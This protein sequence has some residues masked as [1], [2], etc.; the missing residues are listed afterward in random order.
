MCESGDYEVDEATNGC[1]SLLVEVLEQED[2]AAEHVNFDTFRD[3]D[4]N[5]VTPVEL[6]DSDFTA[7]VTPRPASRESD[8]DNDTVEVDDSPSLSEAAHALFVIQAVTVK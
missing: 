7:A 4:G 3:V 1:E 6:S 5:V 8:D 2:E